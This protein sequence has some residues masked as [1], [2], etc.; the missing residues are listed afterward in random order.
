M[1]V[2]AATEFKLLHEG[3]LLVNVQLI[4][5]FKAFNY[6]VFHHLA[7]IGAILGVCSETG[8]LQ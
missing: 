1:N 2:V 5:F 6:L 7:R 8:H 3:H 4:D